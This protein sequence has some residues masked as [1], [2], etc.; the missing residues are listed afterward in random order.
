M[1][2]LQCPCLE[3]PRH[4]GAWRAAVYGVA[5]SRARLKRLSS[6]NYVLT[7]G[8]VWP[9]GPPQ[10]TNVPSLHACLADLASPPIRCGLHQ[11][12][13]KSDQCIS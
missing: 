13:E 3:T 6:S 1:N 7:V 9:Q 12:G 10:K 4:G 11:R 5:Q 8:N 2:P